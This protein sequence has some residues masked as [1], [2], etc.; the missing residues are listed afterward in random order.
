M[1]KS[2]YRLY[3]RNLRCWVQY[4]E[5][6]FLELRKKR[7]NERKKAIKEQR[8]TCSFEN[9]WYCNGVCEGCM[10]QKTREV[11]IYEPVKKDS[12]LTLEECIT[13]DIDPEKGW[14][15]CMDLKTILSRLDELMPEAREIGRLRMQ[16]KTEIE[17]SKILGIP[18]ATIYT[19]I[20]TAY[21]KLRNEFEDFS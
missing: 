3:D 7:N 18:R 6:A 13:D 9:D 21:K 17:I 16:G 10:Y 4:T 19:R 2:K 5:E 15:E 20:K 8:C 14:V 12:T 1:K 11:S